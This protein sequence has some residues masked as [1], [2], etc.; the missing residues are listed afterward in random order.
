MDDC[1]DRSELEDFLTDRLPVE[2]ESR[3][4]THLEGCSA[5][6]QVLETLTAEPVGATARSR[7]STVT[8]LA[9]DEDG[10]KLVASLPSR[11]GPYRVIRVLGQGGMGVV[12]LAEQVALKRLV[13]LKV[14]RHGVNATRGEIARFLA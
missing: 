12:Y 7:S 8:T 2:G 4:L 10:Y 5:C 1:P 14:I 11:I 6:Q 13:A 9:A 3:V